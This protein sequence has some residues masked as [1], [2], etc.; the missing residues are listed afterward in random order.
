MMGGSPNLDCTVTVSAPAGMVV[1]L[2]YLNASLARNLD[3]WSV[4][5]GA[6]AV[7]PPLTSMATGAQ[8]ALS[9]GASSDNA[10]TLAP[11]LTSSGRYLYLRFQSVN[12]SPL[13]AMGRPR[14][15][16]AVITFIAPPRASAAAAAVTPK[17]APTP[18]PLGPYACAAVG[19]KTKP[20]EYS[21]TRNAAYRISSWGGH[22]PPV[23]LNVT[24]LRGKQIM[25]GYQS[26]GSKAVVR[27]ST[28]NTVTLTPCTLNCSLPAWRMEPSSY[29]Y[30]NYYP[31]RW[32]TEAC[33]LSG[34]CLFVHAFTNAAGELL[35]PPRFAMQAAMTVPANAAFI[36]MGYP[37]INALDNDGSAGVCAYPV[38]PAASSTPTPTPSATMSAVARST[39][40]IIEITIRLSGIDGAACTSSPLCL[41]ALQRALA[42]LANVSFSGVRIVAAGAGTGPVAPRRA[43]AAVEHAEA[44]AATHERVTLAYGI[45]QTQ[46]A[47]GGVSAA[48]AALPG[49]G[50][51]AVDGAHTARARVLQAI[52]GGSIMSASLP[53]LE[54]FGYDPTRDASSSLL[55]SVSSEPPSGLWASVQ[56]AV[57]M[58]G[59]DASSRRRMLQ[60]Q[61]SGGS[62]EVAAAATVA[63][64]RDASASGALAS[65]F[66][67]S[68]SAALDN[69]ALAGSDVDAASQAVVAALT[70]GAASSA[71]L[72]TTVS[73][74]PSQAPL[75]NPAATASPGSVPP[76]TA[77]GGLSGGAVAGIVIGCLA[78]VGIAAGFIIAR[79]RNAAAAAA[80]ASRYADPSGAPVKPGHGSGNAGSGAGN[81]APGGRR[82]LSSASLRGASFSAAAMS[83]YASAAAAH[84]AGGRNANANASDRAM[85]SRAAA[86]PAPAHAYAPSPIGSGGDAAGADG[87]TYMQNPGLMRPNAGGLRSASSR[88]PAAAATSP[89]DA[90]Q[91]HGPSSRG[92]SHQ[93]SARP[94]SR[95]PVR[96]TA[97]QASV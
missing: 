66:G 40:A 65:A 4:Y 22:T 23:T 47:F 18:V 56:I 77:S 2:S 19:L 54:S 62:A 60:A 14:G 64:I 25:M 85:P 38:P 39:G 12:W 70:S 46:A 32:V 9:G 8:L 3:F 82:S 33:G 11:V 36:T 67:S 73:S 59:S 50:G 29:G 78:A 5:D 89:A 49:T 28:T 41:L 55:S 80:S 30:V 48:L 53:G 21:S 81:G 68:L 51:A 6:N 90:A 71:V 7:A 27:D 96:R 93:P 87:G 91:A 69:L 16:V 79:K 26:P 43:L 63:S 52:D 17:P 31:H 97:P 86:S 10:T 95:S 44:A 34:T 76:G 15:V 58:P 72:S 42:A 92:L 1:A 24:A 75:V 74:A 37:D 94:V 83:V 20:W 57:P 35:A 61:Q 13:D 45:A 88:P 84:G